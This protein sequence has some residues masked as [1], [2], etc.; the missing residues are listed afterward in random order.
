MKHKLHQH[1]CE[2]HWSGLP[3]PFVL[4]DGEFSEAFDMFWTRE[5]VAEYITDFDIQYSTNGHIIVTKKEYFER[6]AE[7]W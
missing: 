7:K 3:E 5:M 2:Q 1:T 6:V 4:V